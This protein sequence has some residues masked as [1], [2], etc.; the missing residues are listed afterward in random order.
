MKLDSV[1][2]S[3]LA[4]A[5]AGVAEEMG[6]LLVRAALSSNVKERR[7]CS[8]ALFDADGRLVAQAAHIPVHLGAMPDAVAAVLAHDP[9]PRDVF[10]LNDPFAGGTHLPDV[11]LVSPVTLGDDV[12]AFAASRAHH[13]DVGGMTPGSMP[14]TSRELLQEGIVIPPVRLV[15]GGAWADDLLALLLANVRTPEIRR[16]DLRAQMASHRLAERRL[17]ELA[18]RHGRETLLA[19]FADVV[20]YAERRAREAIAAVPDGEYRAQDVIEGD[21]VTDDDIPICARVTVGGDAL[22]V[23]FAGSAE[24]VP[25]NV[26]CP[27]TV[28][29]SACAF[30]L[31]VVLPDDVPTNAGTFAP[32]TVLAPEGTVVNARRPA[33]VAA[34]NVETS[35]RIADTVLLALGQAADVPAQGQG[36]MNNV[37]LGGSGWTYYETVGGGQGASRRAPGASGVHVGMSNTLNTPIEALELEFPLRVERYE[38]REG[39][40]GAGHHGGGDGIVRTLR[41]LEPATLSLLTDRRRHPPRGTTGGGPGATGEN[42]VNGE[43]VPSKAT[44]ELRPGDRVELRTPG[45][46]AWGRRSS[47]GKR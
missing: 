6:A 24:Q 1:T 39:S 44:R 23:D 22:T 19:G 18:E 20:A 31:R 46:G 4:R 38:L 37:V 34:G 45:G 14:A 28:T 32:L 7:D 27:L 26:N 9:E 3:V 41:V 15:R 36:T 13:S 42:L 17:D 8:T 12:V 40:G 10:C 43:R 5:L 47:D 16:G 33:A 21:G 25:G 29:R 35:Q 2:L 11:T 30:A